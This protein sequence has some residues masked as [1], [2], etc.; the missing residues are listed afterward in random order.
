[1]LLEDHHLL[2]LLGQCTRDGEADHARTHDDCL[3]VG[4]HDVPRSLFRVLPCHSMPQSRFLA[5]ATQRSMG[6]SGKVS[7]DKHSVNKIRTNAIRV[8]KGMGMAFTFVH[9]ADWQIGKPFRQFEAEKR[10]ELQRAR[11]Q[12]VE[13]IAEA[14][15]EAGAGHV[16]VAGDVFDSEAIAVEP[17]IGELSRLSRVVWHLLP[18]NHDP[19]R[20]GGI[21]DRLM[22]AGPPANVVCHLEP[23][24]CEIAPGTWLLPAPL[25]SS[26]SGDP[27]AWMDDTATPD[28][29]LRV[30]LAHGEVRGF[31][32]ESESGVLLNPQRA[33]TA[34]LDYLALGDCHGQTMV[35]GRTWYP[36]TPEMDRFPR[37]QPGQALTVAI[38][39]PGAPPRVLSHAVSHFHWLRKSLAVSAPSDVMGLA[40]TLLDAAHPPMRTLLRLELTGDLSLAELAEVEA[41]AATLDGRLF[42]LR[43]RFDGLKAHADE[44][45]LGVLDDAGLREAADRLGRLSQEKGDQER[46]RIAGLALRRLFGFANTTRGSE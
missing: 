31:G 9:T 11:L 37:N 21:W 43:R 45:D 29:A 40:R 41:L 44:T 18:G 26:A 10:G 12:V 30:G 7:V 35:D 46:A 28:G 15:D 22:A 27:T 5:K 23:Q 33:A 1:M 24:P 8:A 16:L 42:H 34:H 25:R 38:D 39:G 14:A 32:G 36:G 6:Q 13:R 17:V 20:S 19:L 3:D 2:A 4:R